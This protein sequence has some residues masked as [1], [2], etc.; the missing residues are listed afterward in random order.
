MPVGLWILPVRKQISSFV[1]AISLFSVPS[2][3]LKSIV[4]WDIKTGAIIKDIIIG[5]EGLRRI[6]FSGH[7][8]VTL[9]T[10]Y[11]KNF[12][13]YDALSGALLYEGEILPQFNRWLGAHWEHGESLRFATSYT[14]GGKLAIDIH[15]LQPSPT[16]LF[17]MVE[18]FIVP[19]HDGEFSFS[20]VSFH[21]SFVT[22]TKITVLDVRDSKILLRTE[23]SPPFYLLPGRFS[24]EG[25]FFACGTLESEI[26]VWKNTSTGYMPWSSLKPRLPF[27]WFS[28]SP[29]AISIMTWGPEGVQ[30]L[31][32][33]T[34]VPSPNKTT[35]NY[36]YE[37]HLVA[38]SK[39]GTRI[40]TARWGDNV[41][42]VFDPLSDAPQRSIKTAMRIL[43]IGIV[44]NTVFMA[45]MH[46][47][48]GWDLEVG[49]TMHSTF[50]ALAAEIAAT[51]TN[52]D[53]AENFT[54][55]ADR[56]WIAFSVNKTIFL[57][58]IQDQ[59]ILYERT[60]DCHVVG[61]RFAPHGP[62]L[63][64]ML[65]SDYR[66]NRAG[67]WGVMLSEMMEQW[68]IV[69]LT[70]EFT[71]GT[72]SRDGL[73]PLHGCC[74]QRESGWIGDSGGRKLLWLPPNWRM[75][76]SLDARWNG[77][78]LALVDGR[79]PVPIIIAF[80]LQFLLPPDYSIQS[81]DT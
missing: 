8:T 62:Q 43:D 69:N 12:H 32:N 44:G 13:T 37:D 6:A 78:F 59:R 54:L 30:L 67:A 61:I 23:P 18:S 81:S 65:I 46:E 28:F 29:T 76:C 33:H 7:Y 5:V 26:H 34:R 41:V 2:T 53:I 15:Q 70:Q 51:G 10:D 80:Q 42:T 11:Y 57:Y 73:F 35:P 27:D 1:L 36:D 39:D 19:L 9:V 24:P 64:F 14:T 52:P 63:C 56:S 31:D 49:E 48:V 4:I 55:S 71:E 20:P 17:P 50:G 74:I 79:H 3:L 21:A 38:Y 60:M 22:E 45:N 40:A 16:T 75:A 58:D 47:L 66:E 72:W 68:Q 25:G 77:N